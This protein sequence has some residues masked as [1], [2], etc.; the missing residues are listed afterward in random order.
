MGWLSDI[1]KEYPALSVETERLQS[2]E[3]K[4]GKLKMDNAAFQNGA[5]A[6]RKRQRFTMFK[7]VL[8]TEH[9]GLVDRTIYCPSC[10]SAMAVF[11]SKSNEKIVCPK[12]NFIAPFQ[13]NEIEKLARILIRDSLFN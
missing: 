11:P 8:W 13:S 2:L 7:G 9:N 12:C 10:K 3:A 4:N 1:L 6:E 5:S